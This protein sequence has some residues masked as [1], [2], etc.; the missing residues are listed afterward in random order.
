MHTVD[1]G[2]FDGVGIMLN[3]DGL[4]GWDFD[5]CLDA[6]G[7]I[8]DETV[9]GYLALLDSY[10]EIS[11]SGTGLRVFLKAKLPPKGR[12]K[13]LIECYENARYL[14]VTGRRLADSRRSLNERQQRLEA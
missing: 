12:K 9:A 13:R 6:A 7:N 5:H 1:H 8:I 14:T 10:S 11:P 2:G 4:A 3:G